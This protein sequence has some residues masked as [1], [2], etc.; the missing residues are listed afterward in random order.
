MRQ[1]PEISA[2]NNLTQRSNLLKMRQAEEELEHLYGRRYT[3]YRK[4][5]RLANELRYEPKFPL[6]IML[7]QTYRCNLG[8]LSC[9]QGYPRLRNRYDAGVSCMPWELYAQII[10]EGREYNCPSVSMHANDEPLLIKD[11]GR[12]IAFARK[13]G[14][15][16][17]IITTNGILFTEERIKEIIDAGVTRILFSI[18]ASTGNT[19]RKVRG[20]DLKEV[21]WAINKVREYR[22][23]NKTH[24]PILR[25]SFVPTTLNRQELESF[26]KKFSRIVDYIEIQPFCT[27]HN[28]NIALVPQNAKP[29][30]DFRCNQPWRSLIVRG[31][32]DVLPCCSYWGP[33]VV[34]GNLRKKSLYQIFNSILVKRMRKDFKRGYYRHPVCR[35]CSQNIY[36]I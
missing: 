10:L 4:Q 28:V 7:E 32:A 33:E 8:C 9:I 34:V 30:I 22:E 29:M 14:F 16:D 19:Y 31:N 5:F 25:A 2:N 18:D 13:H 20:G 17:V 35:K 23:K 6:Y 12:R 24:L 15:M 36:Y 21:I 11:L 3:D 1:S 26:R 27:F